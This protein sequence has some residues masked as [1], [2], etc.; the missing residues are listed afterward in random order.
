MAAESALALEQWGVRW[1]VPADWTDVTADV[2]MP[3]VSRVLR[4]PSREGLLAPSAVLT[5]HDFPGTMTQLSTVNIATWSVLYPDLHVLSV[6][7]FRGGRRVEATATQGGMHLHFTH[8]CTVVEGYSIGLTVTVAE[9]DVPALDR[10]VG[11]ILSSVEYPEHAV[12]LDAPAYAWVPDRAPTPAAGFTDSGGQPV[13]RLDDLNR[14]QSWVS[15]GPVLDRDQVEL[16][17]RLMDSGRGLGRLERGTYARQLQALQDA[18]L[19]DERGRV[20][21]AGST[22]VAPL[23]DAEASVRVITRRG[24]RTSILQAWRGDRGGTT[25]LAGPD[26]AAQW[27]TGPEQPLA[28]RQT[29]DMVQ[30]GTEAAVIAAWVGAGPTWPVLDR[31]VTVMSS[32]MTRLAEGSPVEADDLPES[33]RGRGLLVWSLQAGPDKAPLLFLNIDGVSHAEVVREVDR[34]VVVPISSRNLY[35]RIRMLLEPGLGTRQR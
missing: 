9:A 26:A 17:R 12:A 3:G 25:V 20:T 19:C 31:D 35:R 14:R 27:A 13:E 23:R 29:L 4:G 7:E 15:E 10:T 28:D 11:D 30:S 2:A 32:V 8:A 21:P 16:L 22:V 33:L 5:V 1:S 18:H 6:D 34:A 24:S